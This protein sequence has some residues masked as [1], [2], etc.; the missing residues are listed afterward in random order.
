MRN[1]LDVDVATALVWMEDI[2]PSVLMRRADS[3]TS[4]E[5][6]ALAATF[7]A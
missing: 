7:V 4:L 6:S 3:L 1:A 2:K 5:P